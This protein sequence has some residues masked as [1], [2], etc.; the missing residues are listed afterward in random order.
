M[1]NS[2][3]NIH[4]VF[5]TVSFKSTSKLLLYQLLS[6]SFLQ[7]STISIHPQINWNIIYLWIKSFWVNYFPILWTFFVSYDTYRIKVLDSSKWGK[8]F[9]KFKMRYDLIHIKSTYFFYVIAVVHNWGYQPTTSNNRL[10]G[11]YQLTVNN[12]QP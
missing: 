6:R 12:K 1:N 7:T 11:K 8:T 10:S 4:N 3:G 9:V 2:N 5:R